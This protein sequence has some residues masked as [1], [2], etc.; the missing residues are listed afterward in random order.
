MN[1]SDQDIE[2]FIKGVYDGSI[3]V[4]TLPSE[5]YFAIAEYLK[6]GLYKGFGGSLVDFT[7]TQFTLLSE[8]RE[9]IY[10]FS[11]AKTYQ[12]VKELQELMFEDGKLRPFNKFLEDAKQVYTNYNDNYAKTEFET[13]IGSAQQAVLWDKIEAQADILPYLQFDAVMDANTTDECEHMNGITAPV[14]DPIWST[15]YPPNHWNCRSTVRQMDITTTPSSKSDISKAQKLTE[16]H[17]PDVFQMN[18]GKDKVVFQK[19][20]P[21]FDVAKEDRKL[22]KENFNLPIPETD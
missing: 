14:D 16:A 21:Y 3:T 22:A 4:D 11:A 17:I 13:T 5:L 1:Y 12:Q 20:H 19:D 7:G 18:V 8:L 10:M 15:C 9:N 2:D 6:K